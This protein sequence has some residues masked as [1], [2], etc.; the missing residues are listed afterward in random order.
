MKIRKMLKK[1][2]FVTVLSSIF[3]TLIMCLILS[4]FNKDYSQKIVKVGFV[5]IGDSSTAYTNNFCR[6]QMELEDVF[7]N[8]VITVAKYNIPEGNCEGAIRDLI[9]EG[10][11][12]I[13][14]TSYGYGEVMKKMAAENPKIQFVQATCSDANVQ[15]V[16]ANYHNCMGRIYQGRYVAGL[17]AGMKLRE[18]IEQ[19]KLTPA[20][21]KIGYVA[22]FPYAEVISGY[23]AFLLGVRSVVP[24]AVMVVR[25]TDTWSNTVIE[26]RV[27][28][29]LIDE[30]CVVIS[31]HS[32]TTG[33]AAACETASTRYGKTVFHVAYNQSMTDVAPTTSLIATRINWTP[34]IISAVEAVIKGK[35]IESVVKGDVF[36]NDIAAGFEYGWC[37]MVGLNN[38]IAAEGTKEAIETTIRQ[39]KNKNFLIFKGDYI[40]V[41]PFDENDTYDLRKPFVE[42]ENQSAP[43]F[44]YVLTEVITIE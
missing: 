10:C 43:S 28:E 2:Y 40:G 33:P 39:F 36:G 16:L 9:F 20:E 29:I 41:N 34:Y 14:G 37:E 31:Q 15:P 30:G 24:E 18:L 1:K 32:D 42:N 13:F 19:D 25:Y 3:M 26:R 35:K 38:L 5:Y 11:D 44:N 23:T 7:P 17:V 4:F 27:A 21:A 12:M 6:S 22:A 8:N